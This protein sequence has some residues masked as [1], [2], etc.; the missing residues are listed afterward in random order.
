MTLLNA[1][2]SEHIQSQVT[3][4]LKEDI[5]SGD[6]T[7]QLI[8]DDQEITATVISREPAVLCGQ[9]WVNEVFAQLGNR[10]TLTWHNNEGDTLESDKPFL[11]IKGHARTILTG[12]R[13]A[14]NFLQTLSYTATVT[15]QY[16]EIVSSTQLTILDTRKTIPGMRR[17]QKYAVTVGGGKNHRMGLYDAFLIKENHIMAAGSIANAVSMAQK[18]APGKTIEVETENLEEVAMAVA[19]GAD[20][21]MLDNFSYE[22][23]SKAVSDYK[24][25]VKFEASG[26]MD[27]DRLLK[28][29]ETGVDFVSIG[30][31][32]KHIQAIDLSLR[33]SQE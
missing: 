13:T 14:L 26:N 12:E 11:T 6:I 1:L 27:K 3:F 17:A 15:R 28:V 20:I 19:A 31:L 4:A 22:D 9:A 33:V 18:I 7:A 32:T 5:G 16:S 2:L 30:A 24:G 8:P 29:A 21:I 23:M 25:Q 10:T